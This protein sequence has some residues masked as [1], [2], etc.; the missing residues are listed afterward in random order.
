MGLFVFTQ[1]LFVPTTYSEA[2]PW[3]H[4]EIRNPTLPIKYINIK[5]IKISV[6]FPKIKPFASRR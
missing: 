6:A 4:I 5:R 1:E 3:Q 2:I